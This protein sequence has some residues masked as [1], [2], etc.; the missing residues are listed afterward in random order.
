MAF[1][2]LET[3]VGPLYQG[4]TGRGVG[5][6][7]QGSLSELIVSN[8]RGKYAELASRGA[9]FSLFTANTGATVAAGHVAP[10][11]AAAATTLTL[12]NPVGSGVNFEIVAG[13]LTHLTGTPGTGSWS[14]CVANAVGA[15]VITATANATAKSGLAG[16]A[17]SAGV[18]YTATALTAG[19][20][21]VVQR[22]FPNS[23]F[24]GAIGATSLNLNM[25]DLVDGAL[26]IPPGWIVSLAPPATGTTHVVM[27]QIVYAE[28]Q[29]A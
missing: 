24:A 8:G 12:S 4:S 17:A 9:L 21:H 1:N 7:R 15:T 27:A 18:G 16:G 2:D 23:M 19:P 25:V 26:V 22:Q 5:R 29:I 11:A 20:L 3:F 6:L 28:I 14:W 10:P 13:H